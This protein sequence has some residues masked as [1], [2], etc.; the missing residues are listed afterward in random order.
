M[1][2]TLTSADIVQPESTSDCTSEFQSF[3]ESI[4]KIEKKE[5][6]KNTISRFLHEHW[7]I[8]DGRL[9]YWLSRTTRAY[10]LNRF[11]RE[12][13]NECL[14]C[15]H[16]YDKQKFNNIQKKN[17]KIMMIIH[18]CFYRVIHKNHITV[19]AQK[20]FAAITLSVDHSDNNYYSLVLIKLFGTFHYIF[21]KFTM[22]DEKRRDEM[23]FVL[24]RLINLLLC[25]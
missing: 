13:V 7:E 8:R 15:M 17:L 25:Q 21:I 6:K 24:L 4:R 20:Y 5:E 10:N 19:L 14:L 3:I 12:G 23:I 11:K 18:S 2:R 1:R 22:A 9:G 16:V